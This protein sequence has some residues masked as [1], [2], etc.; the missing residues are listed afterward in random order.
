MRAFDRCYNENSGCSF[1][2]TFNRDWKADNNLLYVVVVWFFLL[3]SRTLSLPLSIRCSRYI[4]VKNVDEE[5]ICVNTRKCDRVHPNLLHLPMYRIFLGSWNTGR[6]TREPFVRS[7]GTIQEIDREEGWLQKLRRNSG[8]KPTGG[9]I[10]D[11]VVCSFCL[12]HYNSVILIW[13]QWGVLKLMC[14]QLSLGSNEISFL[15]TVVQL[16]VNL[17]SIISWNT[18]ALDPNRVISTRI[19]PTQYF[20]CRHIVL[21]TSPHNKSTIKQQHHSQWSCLDQW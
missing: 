13:D 14:C 20:V 17:Y 11:S 6:K 3:L 21:S 19:E 10:L 12:F 16:V 9:Y 5:E 7:H 2:F 8:P 18:T 15:M 4:T 1:K